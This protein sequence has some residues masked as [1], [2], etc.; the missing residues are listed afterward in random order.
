MSAVCVPGLGAAILLCHRPGWR[1]AS[2]PIPLA[3][4]PSPEQG[5]P[6]KLRAPLPMEEQSLFLIQDPVGCDN[7]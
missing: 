2:C 1:A 5:Q 4:S 3:P 6:G 7:P